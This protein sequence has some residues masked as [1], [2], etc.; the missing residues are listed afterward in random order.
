MFSGRA[1]RHYGGIFFGLFYGEPE[2]G[3]RRVDFRKAK[4]VDQIKQVLGGI[5]LGAVFFAFFWI[6]LFLAAELEPQLRGQ[7]GTSQTSRK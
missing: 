4:R 3:G 1:Q 2:L 5:L 6:G 7:H